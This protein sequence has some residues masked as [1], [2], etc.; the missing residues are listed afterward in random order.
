[1]KSERRFA[2]TSASKPLQTART[3]ARTAFQK[4]IARECGTSSD[5]AE[6]RVPSTLRG[7]RRATGAIREDDWGVLTT[8]RPTT[9]IEGSPAKTTAVLRALRSYLATPMCEWTGSLPG[10]R[11]GTLLI[12][13]VDRLSV[14][15]QQALCA[16]LEAPGGAVRVIA[17]SSR[18]LFPLIGRGL[19]LADL[20]YRLNVVRVV[21]KRGGR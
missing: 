10:A 7:P 12:R 16:W 11:P 20:Y 14:A 17:T 8:M 2:S 1:M 13:D 4:N 19:F 18:H 3:G 15:D 6:W 21:L 9:L 5:P